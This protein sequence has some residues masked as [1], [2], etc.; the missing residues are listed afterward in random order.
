MLRSEAFP[1]SWEPLASA[2]LSDGAH[3]VAVASWKGTASV[4]IW[5]PFYFHNYMSSNPS[6]PADYLSDLGAL[7]TS[8]FYASG[9]LFV[10]S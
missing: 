9:T 7:I 6:S 3:T 10:V 2:K 8:P 4:L 5:P 1:G